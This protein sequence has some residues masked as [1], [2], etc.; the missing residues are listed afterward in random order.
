MKTLVRLAPILLLLASCST[1]STKIVSAWKLPET[2]PLQFERIMAL[3]LV[4]EPSIRR[5]GEQ[6]LVQQITRAK[7]FP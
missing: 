6:E 2:G 3:V 7:A 1:S 4:Q 5:A